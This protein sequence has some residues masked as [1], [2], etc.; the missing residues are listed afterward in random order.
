LIGFLLESGQGGKILRVGYEE[1][2]D[3]DSGRFPKLIRKILAKTVLREPRTEPKRMRVG[4]KW[5]LEKPD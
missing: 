1:F 3:N 2:D 5:N 4:S